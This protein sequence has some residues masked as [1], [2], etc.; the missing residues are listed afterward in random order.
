[1]HRIFSVTLLHSPILCETVNA[2]FF[3]RHVLDTNGFSQ[4]SA[5]IL[6]L[7]FHQFRRAGD[8]QRFPVTRR[9]PYF[10]LSQIMTIS[11]E[12]VSVP[13]LWASPMFLIS[14]SEPFQTNAVERTS[15]TLTSLHCLEYTVGLCD[16]AFFFG[17]SN[18]RF[19]FGNLRF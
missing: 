6:L 1:M 4:S 19:F 9:H 10:L 7:D 17:T 15:V 5:L 14:S 18:A 8:R 3:R 12:P 11:I 16:G 13:F 2:S